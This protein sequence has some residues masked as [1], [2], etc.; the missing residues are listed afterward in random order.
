MNQIINKEDMRTSPCE[1]DLI[2]LCIQVFEEERKINMGAGSIKQTVKILYCNETISSSSGGRRTIGIVCPE[3]ISMDLTSKV[4]VRSGFRTHAGIETYYDEKGKHSHDPN[5]TK[6]EWSCDKGHCGPYRSVSDCP[7]PGCN[8]GYTVL[9]TDPYMF[10]AAL[11]ERRKIE[12]CEREA[13][14]ASERAK[15]GDSAKDVLQ[16]SSDGKCSI[17]NYIYSNIITIGANESGNTLYYSIPAMTVSGFNDFF[18]QNAIATGYHTKMEQPELTK[19]M[20]LQVQPDVIKMEVT[21][22][23]RTYTGI[24]TAEPIEDEKK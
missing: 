10:P 6:T 4:Y 23:N 9:R 20:P 15:S 21:Y 17:S 13:K 3:C 22:G 16:E 7:V 24:L 14:K 2:K 12:D 18:H 8:K 5:V 11:K 1:N 19:T